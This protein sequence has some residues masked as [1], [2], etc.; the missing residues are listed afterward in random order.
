MSYIHLDDGRAIFKGDVSQRT[1]LIRR[2]IPPGTHPLFAE[3]SEARP[4]HWLDTIDYPKGIFRARHEAVLSQIA[5]SDQNVKLTISRYGGRTFEYAG[6]WMV[7]GHPLVPHV[8]VRPGLDHTMI[9]DA[10]DDARV[11]IAINYW[12]LPLG[13]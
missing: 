9:L 5:I 3:M 6:P 2:N 7:E 4:P 1:I 10:M 12:L 8:H 11:T 13:G